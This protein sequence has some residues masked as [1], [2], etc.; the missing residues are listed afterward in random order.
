MERHAWY[1][2]T[3]AQAYSA[4]FR[5]VVGPAIG[6]LLE[7]VGVR[8][9][10]RV[11][12][13]ACGPGRVGAAIR[14][15]GGTPVELDFSAAMT[16]LAQREVPGAPVVRA[17]ALALPWR[18][19]SVDAVVSNFGLLHFADPERALGE[20]A[21]VVRPGGRVAW[22][23]W[24]EEAVLFQLIPKAIGALG[25]TPPMPEGPAF[26][27]YGRP[28]ELVAALGRAGLVDGGYR[29]ARWTTHLPDVE[30]VWT[31]FSQG[32][33]RTRAMIQ[34]LSDEER[35]RVRARL[36]DALER[37]RFQGQLRLPTQALVGYAARPA[38]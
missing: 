3:V 30:T 37:Y 11:L 6:P 31:M 2:P 34:A 19:G 10:L 26:F 1:Q 12:D 13:L 8:P 23:V 38:A 36:A 4:S 21:R 24:T 14:A 29:V 15:R 18:A 17:S 28:A 5:D 35:T 22:S 16:R 7:A 25:L 20:A 32:S 33:A 27:R 9:P